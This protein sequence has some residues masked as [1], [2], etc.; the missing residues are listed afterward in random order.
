ML[1]F[2]HRYED[3]WVAV[4]PLFLICFCW[5]IGTE[6]TV[7]LILHPARARTLLLAQRVCFF[8]ILTSSCAPSFALTTLTLNSSQNS[9]GIFLTQNLCSSCFLCLK[10]L[11]LFKWLAPLSLSFKTP[12]KKSTYSERLF[13]TTWSKVGSPS[14]SL[15]RNHQ[16][17]VYIL[18]KMYHKLEVFLFTYVFISKYEFQRGRNLPVWLTVVFSVPRIESV[19][20]IVAI[21]NI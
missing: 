12:L 16:H 10:C 21:Q 3:V 13:L 8:H 11:Q 20:Q 6:L 14:I 4:Y 18:W 15:F 17:H 5:L 1:C 2:I 9:P 19:W 7:M